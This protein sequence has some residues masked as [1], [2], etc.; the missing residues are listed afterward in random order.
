MSQIGEGCKEGSR[1]RVG[2]DSVFLKDRVQNMREVINE[3]GFDF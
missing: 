3:N 2:G 1:Q